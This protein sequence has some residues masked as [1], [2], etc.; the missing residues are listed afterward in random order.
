[1][2]SGFYFAMKKL[3]LLTFLFPCCLQAQPHWKIIASFP[4]P[5]MKGFFPYFISGRYGF[6][7]SA[8]PFSNVYGDTTFLYRTTDGGL[9]WTLTNF[10]QLEALRFDGIF[11][12]NPKHG[13]IHCLGYLNSSP[14]SQLFETNDSGMSWKQISN[15]SWTTFW[16]VPNMYYFNNTIF[17]NGYRS[18]DDG[19]TWVNVDNS[20]TYND[21]VGNGD[22]VIDFRTFGSPPYV[23]GN[24]LF[25]T[26]GGKNWQRN[27]YGPPIGYSACFIYHTRTV[28]TASEEMGNPPSA[29]SPYYHAGPWIDYDGNCIWRSIDGG[30]DWKVVTSPLRNGKIVLTGAI[31]SNGCATYAQQQD[32]S[33]DIPDVGMLRSTDLG[34]TWQHVGGPALALDTVNG[35]CYATDNEISVVGNGA[36]VYANDG[37]GNLWKTTDGGDGALGT[38]TSEKI[39]VGAFPSVAACSRAE[40]LA[41]VFGINCANGFTLTSATLEG[42]TAHFALDSLPAMPY[43]IGGSV[44]DTFFIRFNPAKTVGTFSTTLHITGTIVGPDTTLPFDTVIAVSATSIASPMSFTSSVDSLGFGPVSTCH[45]EVDSSIVFVN[46]GC[47]PDTI[48][49]ITLTGTVFFGSNDT[50]PII[51]APGDSLVLSYKFIPA[52]PGSFSG[53]TKL[54]VESMGLTKDPT[55]GLSGTGLP[56]QATLS[57]SDTAL[58][59]GT[60]SRCNA[61]GDTVVTFT[62]TGCDSLALTGASVAAGSG[63]TLLA[64]GDTVLAPGES[65]RYT[66]GFWDTT[67][68]E[69]VSALHMRAIG[70]HGGNTIDITVPLRAMVV[71]GSRLAAL[72]TQS[73][74]VGTTSICEERD[75]S[76]TIKNTGCEPDT[77]TTLSFANTTFSSLQPLPI[78]IPPHSDTTISI[79]TVIDTTGHATANT[80]TLEVTGNLDAPL[81]PVVL[82][83]GIQYPDHFSLALSAPDSAPV[84]ATVPVYVLRKGTVPSQAAELDFSLVYND[85]LLGYL[86]PIQPDISSIASTLLP[87]G[88]MERS[89]AMKP[90]SDR[91]TIATIQ[92]QSYLTRNDVTPITLTGQNFQVV[93]PTP[94]ACIASLDTGAVGQNFTLELAC[95]YGPMIS[96]IKNVPFKITSIETGADLLNFRVSSSDPRYRSCEAQLLNILGTIEE[97]KPLTASP[98]TSVSFDIHALPAGAYFLRVSGGGYAVA[99]PIMVLK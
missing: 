86:Q 41:K 73:I 8:E 65:A 25:S 90:A 70:A 75:S 78:I 97:A 79:A 60:F 14:V 95:G 34:L 39:S 15:L 59:L 30:G 1:M 83:R 38:P 89:F 56:S 64:G 42:D 62:N 76:I 66:I 98:N 13:Y 48:S 71:A 94:A 36:V 85:D 40:V 49:S 63:F 67:A 84:R 21:A 20:H 26:D 31:A 77:I 82:S 12:E 46:Y 35:T 17:V 88:L 7:Y 58:D 5:S 68:G 93:G 22:S 53:S 27:S 24:C 69:L 32:V 99:R 80:D 74:D 4:N 55:I 72:N 2:A 19:N 91:D 9:S 47:G 44:I 18:I 61:A 81:L 43:S 54:H 16:T 23:Y 87:S 57:L 3:F 45:G 11:F 10:P 96:T 28:F 50:L 52:N 51:L 6:I 37:E 92:F 33:L 29:T